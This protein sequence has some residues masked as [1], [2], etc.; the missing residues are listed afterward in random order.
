MDFIKTKS[1]Y[2]E[3]KKHSETK[4]GTIFER[5]I[6]TLGGLNLFSFTQTPI[7]TSGNL[8]ISVDNTV[9]SQRKIEKNSWVSNGVS[10][11]N[12]NV[13]TLETIAQLGDV[14][15]D[16][17]SNE[18]NITIKK[19]FYRLQDFSYYGSLSKMIETSLNNIVNTFPGEIYV[20]CNANNEDEGYLVKFKTYDY[21]SKTYG[22]GILGQVD[23][24]GNTIVDIF[25]DDKKENESV[26]FI[27]NPFNLNF[28]ISGSS[29]ADNV[30][31]YFFYEDNKNNYQIINDR[32][33]I[34]KPTVQGD[35]VIGYD[36]IYYDVSDLDIIFNIPESIKEAYS[37]IDKRVILC[38]GVC[39]CQV[40]FKTRED[41]KEIFEF[42]AFLG[43]NDKV[44]YLTSKNYLEMHIRPKESV[45]NKFI[46]DL[47]IFETYL[48]TKKE[49]AQSNMTNYTSTFEVIQED[50]DGN[51]VKT[52]EDFIIPIDNG[53]YNIDILSVSFQKAVDK[54][55]RIALYYDEHFCDNLYRSMTHESI[56]NFDWTHNREYTE[57][58]AEDLIIGG[59]KISNIIHLFGREF[60]EIKNYID[61]IKYT[62]TLTYDNK[63]NL[64]DYFLTDVAELKGWDIISIYPYNL[65]EYYIDSY[66]NRHSDDYNV[67]GNTYEGYKINRNFSQFATTDIIQPYKI[68]SKLSNGIFVY[69]D[70]DG[71]IQEKVN[72]KSR[73][74]DLFTDCLSFGTISSFMDNQEY[75]LKDVNNEFIKRLSLSS[76]S[77]L[78]TKGT[79][80]GIEEIVGLFRVLLVPSCVF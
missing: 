19:D 48:L 4:D 18:A 29:F 12:E 7:Y 50:V 32:H 2:V 21:E 69:C 26:Y 8:I 10:K 72:Y 73:R 53:G 47:S 76:P 51:W 64:S 5:D 6:T 27:S 44:Y 38:P 70:C 37:N 60:D 46:N 41:K 33:E 74:K 39:L 40:I 14:E 9:P 23:Y 25:D 36:S 1:S 55:S 75:S 20:P 43:D 42:K 77:I 3:R 31:K 79:I 24:S 11:E 78:K 67:S 65:E 16:S 58:D 66:N 34:T 56:K 13:W 59:N 54:F 80:E 45:Y 71:K 52:L 28:H 62:N 61:G 35:V 30:D 49:S 17:S 22:E 63:N 68:K 15:T 57:G